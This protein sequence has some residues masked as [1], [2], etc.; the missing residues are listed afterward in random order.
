MKSLQSKQKEV[1]E[2][3]NFHTQLESL[4]LGLASETGELCDYI[5]KYTNLKIPKPGDDISNLP[6]EI[7]KECADVLIYLLQIANTL[8][9]DLEK[10][11]HKKADINLQ[12]HT[13][14]KEFGSDRLK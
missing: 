1:T 4:A 13:K 5:A 11:F 9:F 3:C 14:L 6:V 8:D 2:K 7:K 10:E 12:R